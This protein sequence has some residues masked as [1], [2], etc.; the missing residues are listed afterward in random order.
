MER[1]ER[2]W[3]AS[4]AAGAMLLVIPFLIFVRYHDYSLATP[5]I[6]TSF[7][8]LAAVGI[9]LGL[10]MEIAGAISRVLILSG[11]IT[12]M[13]DIQVE[14][15]ERDGILWGTFGASLIF[16][17]LLRRQLA[18]V[19][20][21]VLVVLLVSSA[22]LPAGRVAAITHPVEKPAPG[23]P[24]LPNFLHIILDEQIGVEGI[25]AEFDPDGHHT[26]ALQSFYLDRG[27]QVF[28]RSYSRYFDTSFSL[29][30]L[31]NF[32]TGAVSGNHDVRVGTGFALTNNAYFDLMTKRGYQIHVYQ[33]DYLDFCRSEGANI[34]SCF[35]YHLESIKSIEDAPLGISEKIRVVLSMYARLSNLFSRHVPALRR[36]SSVSTI[37]VFDKL[38]ADMLRADP[39]SLFLVHLMLPHYPYAYRANC[40]LRPSTADWLYAHDERLRPRRNDAASREERYPRYLEQVAC[41]NLKLGSL[42]DALEDVGLLEQT[43]ILVHGDHGSRIDLLP[44]TAWWDSEL[45]ATDYVDLFSTLVA[46]KTPDGR[47]AYDRRMLPLD[48]LFSM[49]V[50]RKEVPT[51]EG[52]IGNDHVMLR[53]GK[54]R[55]FLERAMP[56]FSRAPAPHAAER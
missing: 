28:G 13:V 56:E 34:A 23:N 44:P 11:L 3:A 50:R 39:G 52:W 20:S 4:L 22:V 8:L 35:T 9:L 54:S 21:V 46:F 37:A 25:P 27:F 18:R 41:L 10:A 29:S 6:L 51:G 2:T 14:S 40:E 33:T 16:G 32:E 24:A 17:W 49:L 45:T 48:S 36:V 7:G 26:Q 55:K 38:Q 43:M 30:N 19:G 15:P 12:L 1:I 31:F 47:A 5:E 53:R 42:F